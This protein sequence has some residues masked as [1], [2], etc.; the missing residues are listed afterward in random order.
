MKMIRT[1]G[2]CSSLRS[3]NRS[4]IVSYRHCY[5]QCLR[6]VAVVKVHM[7][8]CHNHEIYKYEGTGGTKKS[9]LRVSQIHKSYTS[10]SFLVLVYDVGWDAR[11]EFI[12]SNFFSLQAITRDHSLENKKNAQ[13]SDAS[14]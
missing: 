1:N 11:L 4:Y 14:P 10:P 12:F 6:T 3:P 2:T 13:K 5:E 8:D 9:S 7:N